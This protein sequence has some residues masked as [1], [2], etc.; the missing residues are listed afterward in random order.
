[1]NFS[2]LEKGI[3]FMKIKTQ[4]NKSILKVIKK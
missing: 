3:Y 1:M 2:Q 4:R